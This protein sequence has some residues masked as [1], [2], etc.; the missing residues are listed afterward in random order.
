MDH[1]SESLYS[2][3]PLYQNEERDR[4]V[5]LFNDILPVKL[6]LNNTLNCFETY[7][8]IILITSFVVPFRTPSGIQRFMDMVRVAKI[9]VFSGKFSLINELLAVSFLKFQGFIAGLISF[10]THMKFESVNRK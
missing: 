1:C 6:S 9:K 4:K 5:F 2:K 7:S 10:P 8:D 3:N